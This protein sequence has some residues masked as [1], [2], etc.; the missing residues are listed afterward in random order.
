MIR[1]IN[2]F[3]LAFILCV[4]Q[5]SV[6]F[7]LATHG[8]LTYKTYQASTIADGDFLGTLGI[9]NSVSPFGNIYIDTS[10]T[11]IIF[12]GAPVIRFPAQIIRKDLN[13]VDDVF[14]VVS[15]LMR[16]SI[17]EDD[18]NSHNFLLCNIKSLNEGNGDPDPYPDPPERPINHFY[19]PVNDSGLSLLSLNT[20][21]NPD[22]A[23]GVDDAFATTLA[24]D[25]TRRN[26]FTVFDAIESMY[27]ALTGHESTNGT[28]NIGPDG[29]VGPHDVLRSAYWATTFRSLGDIVHLVED[30]A[31]PQHTRNDP[32]S[33]DCLDVFNGIFGHES[34]FESYLE[35][36]VTNQSNAIDKVAETDIEVT[37][38]P[39]LVIS[40]YP[41]PIFN[42][43]SDYWSTRE[44]QNGRGM[45]DYSNRE[46]FSAGR[47]LSDRDNF[48]LGPYYYDEP[49]NDPG[50]Y[51]TIYSWSDAGGYHTYL[52]DA[53]EDKLN[54][55]ETVTNITTKQS[56]LGDAISY[57]GGVADYS[58]SLDQNIYDIQADLLL[59]RAVAY[60]AGL[61][62]YFFRGRFEIVSK[63]DDAS[64]MTVKIKNI[65]RIGD[66]PDGLR[67]D[68]GTDSRFEVFYDK[69]DG[70]RARIPL[71]SAVV[72]DA[73]GNDDPGAVTINASGQAV[74]NAGEIVE[75][76]GTITISFDL[77]TDMGTDLIQGLWSPFTF[78]YKGQ[79]GEEE[80]IAAIVFSRTS[81]LAFYE[82]CNNEDCDIKLGFHATESKDTGTTWKHYTDGPADLTDNYIGS[83]TYIGNKEILAYGVEYSGTEA[84]SNYFIARHYH[85]FDE[86]KT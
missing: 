7:E 40:D 31:Q 47:N 53:V 55:S 21:K 17:R 37:N 78:V 39:E 45:A 73:A 28:A 84:G 49:S 13:L 41:K 48:G 58:Y 32:H 9:E 57:W 52:A 67:L 62:D 36:R 29:Y 65:S 10:N 56:L 81:M 79:V 74:L 4:P 19:D 26:H 68:A 75:P 35:A 23:I 20:E 76:D 83:A 51:N 14:T 16:G 3:I 25:T 63:Q 70:T 54:Q 34:F 69:P 77:P 27:R 24:K 71:T 44:G 85:S 5:I 61:I 82:D 86:G 43:Y 15:W 33:G 46:F 66:A 60:S 2:Q 30:V 72:A 8:L 80:G 12:R 18:N 64:Q 6:A 1:I 59:P 11:D 38:Y 22:W 42:R 50:T